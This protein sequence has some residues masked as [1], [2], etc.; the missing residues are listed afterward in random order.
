LTDEV[1]LSAGMRY[2]HDAKSYFE[3]GFIF[4]PIQ[5]GGAD[6][7][8][9]MTP[10]FAID[11]KPSDDVTVFANVARGFKAGG[12]NTLNFAPVNAFK[13]EFVWSYETGV[14]GELLYGGL[15]LAA[16]A[17]RMDYSNLQETVYA[18]GPGGV[19]VA[20]VENVPSASIKGI[21]LE[22]EGRPLDGLSLGL[23]GS[24][25]DTRVNTFVS[26]DPL[27]PE[28]GVEDFAGNRLA[29][30]PAWQLALNGA[31]SYPLAASLSATLRADYAWRSHQFFELFNHPLEAQGAYGLLNLRASLEGADGRW[32]VALFGENVTNRRYL[33]NA[34]ASVIIPGIPMNIAS[35]GEPATWGASVSYRF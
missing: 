35:L 23:A 30:A 24:W 11:Y 4:G 15:S 8:D 14:K 13:P 2:T 10:R 7:W 27:Y 33:N 32:E 16:T 17:F 19:P 21:E 6:S 1:R 29:R 9:A 31:Y 5:G 26:I 22:V 34:F 28:L 12:F 18:P 20:N 3:T 25:L